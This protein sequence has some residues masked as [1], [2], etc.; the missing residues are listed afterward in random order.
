MTEMAR[1]RDHQC[2]RANHRLLAI[3]M[4]ILRNQRKFKCG[5]RGK[6]RWRAKRPNA[7]DLPSSPCPP[8]Q[9]PSPFQ[10]TSFHVHSVYH[11]CT[12]EIF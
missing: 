7:L 8:E 1:W 10:D 6:E 12:A 3:I 11:L 5:L 9:P 2:V 4:E